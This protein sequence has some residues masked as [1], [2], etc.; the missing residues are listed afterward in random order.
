MTKLRFAAVRLSATIALAVSSGAACADDLA[1]AAAASLTEAF[2]DIGKSFEANHPGS[3]VIFTFAASG[4]LLQQLAQGT[5]ADVFAS[6]DE[7]TMDKALKQNLI[8][9]STR[10]V[11]AGNSLVLIVPAATES[12]PSSAADLLHG[13]VHRIAIGNP[14]LSP[15]GRYAQEAL[16]IAGIRSEIEQKL[17]PMES[18]RQALASVMHGNADAGIVYSSDAQLEKDAVKNALTLPTK[19]PIHYSAAVAVS[20][21]S[22]VLAKT[23]IAYLQST[24]GRTVLQKYG[25]VAP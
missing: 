7:A 6:A 15:A 24:D 21:H 2:Q 8:N 14:A 5:V 22:P 11:F 16:D 20:S 23:F 1:V 12:P 17:V 25:F 13:D 3:H 4:A 19:T 10:V 9:G 18:V